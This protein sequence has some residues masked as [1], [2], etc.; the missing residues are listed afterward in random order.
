MSEIQA[1]TSS[2]K[3]HILQVASAVPVQTVAADLPKDF[4]QSNL[5]ISAEAQYLFEMNKY[6]TGLERAE[7]TEV[8]AYLSQGN[9][10]LQQKAVEHFTQ[11]QEKLIGLQIVVQDNNNVSGAELLNT[12]FALDETTAIIARPL[13]TNIFRLDGKEDFIHARQGNF[14]SLQDQ[15]DLLENSSIGVLGMQASVNLFGS[16]ANALAESGNVFYSVDDVLYFNYVHQKAKDAISFFDAPDDLKF[17]LSNFLQEGIK[18]QNQMQTKVL[19]EAGAF[20]N[21]PLHGP[22]VRE[23]LRLGSV[24]QHYNYQY[25]NALQTN[26][27]SVLD[28]AAIL[29]NLL[30]GNADLA[31]FSPDKINEALSFYEKDYVR[32]ERAL[33]KDFSSIEP[34]VKT[35][36]DAE[37]LSAG[38]SYAQ[39]VIEKIQAY[40]F[41]VKASG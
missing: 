10:P 6:L 16:V 27:L 19:S 29:H 3:N 17:E 39:G 14:Q 41:T 30:E 7:R 2:V 36:F 22:A 12:D 15:L 24:A 1:V 11:T 40:I 4:P 5:H 9:D 8:L 18:F 35:F 32:F 20:A 21:H 26:D 23:N 28:S 13:T 37:D 25:Q 34:E 33:N 31:R 38:S